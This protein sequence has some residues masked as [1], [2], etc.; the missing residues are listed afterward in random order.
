MRVGANTRAQMRKL[1]RVW[2][3][4]EHILIS[5]D[6]GSG[7]TTLERLI[8]QI[9][10]EKGGHVVVFVAKLSPDETILTDYKGWVRWKEWK[11]N[12]GP[13]E[14]RVLL[15]PDTTKVKT[16]PEKM[17]LQKKVFTDAINDLADRG[18][19]TV[20]FDEGLY[21]CSPTFMNLGQ[22]IAMLHAMG[23]SS[24]LT[25]I[26][27]M[28]RPTNVPLILFGSASHA[29]IGRT[30]MD[31]DLKR[32]SEMGGRESAKSLATRISALGRRDFLWIP[33]AQDWAPEIV[34]VSR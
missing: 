24:K 11:K 15:W 10:I 21:M 17:A 27:V 25:I 32:L 19:W 28:Q 26:T 30:R 2:R 20:A 5:G 18:K 1:A 31:S 14:N 9:R 6:T 12:P 8:T 23:R 7:K 34:N 22:E 13:D 33:V 4:G 29:F 16:L 3:Q